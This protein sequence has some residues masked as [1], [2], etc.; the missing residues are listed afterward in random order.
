MS[1]IRIRFS[2]SDRALASPESFLSLLTS[3]ALKREVEVS[4]NRREVVDIQFS[5]VQYSLATRLKHLTS[6]ASERI[7]RSHQGVIDSRWA[8]ENPEPIGLARRHVWF[9]GEN[10]RPPSTD[11]DATLCFDLDPLGGRNAYLPL[12]WFG[13]GVLGPAHSIFMDPAPHV[14]RL[15]VGRIPERIPENF[16]VA[17]INNPHPMRFHAIQALRRFGVVDVFGRAVGRS[18]PNKAMLHGRY[19]FMLCFE[20]DLYPGYVTEKPI[21][22]WAAGTVPLWW[23][24]DPAGY[25]NP[26]ALINAADFSTIADF[27]ESASRLSLNEGLWQR[28]FSQPLLLRRPDLQPAKDV[29]GRLVSE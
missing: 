28:A 25:L 4:T 18:L 21:E 13:I 23:G 16:A 19:K 8:R 20:N 14:D 3:H 26:E 11:W 12:W 29:L 22:A 15:L 17:L 5:S 2:S 7:R 1:A 6:A 9:T 10:V 24:S 27:A